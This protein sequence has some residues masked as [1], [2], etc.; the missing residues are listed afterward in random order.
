MLRGLDFFKIPAELRPAGLV[1]QAQLQ[2]KYTDMLQKATQLIEAA[3]TDIITAMT[4]DNNGL[5]TA[6]LLLC[7]D[8]GNEFRLEV[9]D[10]PSEA[11][12]LEEYRYMFQY[13]QPNDVIEADLWLKNL[14]KRAAEGC[15][16]KAS[17][18]RVRTERG[19]PVFCTCLTLSLEISQAK[20]HV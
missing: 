9:F 18:K 5:A 10:P 11:Q 15:G 16:F 6:E 12:G 13:L 20:V 8:E 2:K 19:D 1:L 4:P 7:R 17:V 14:L 3:Q